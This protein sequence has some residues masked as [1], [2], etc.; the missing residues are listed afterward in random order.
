MANKISTKSYLVKRL[1]DSG[2]NIEKLDNLRYIETDSRKWSVII[3]GGVST[4]F[5]TCYK[6]GNI[7]LYDGNRFLNSRIFVD[8]DSIEV[9][10]EHFNSKGIINKHYSYGNNNNNA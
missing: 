10:I 4:V 8:T 5:L 7:H 9:L 6:N 1:K 3:D 2:F